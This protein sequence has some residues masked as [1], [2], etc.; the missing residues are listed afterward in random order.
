MTSQVKIRETGG[1]SLAAGIVELLRTFDFFPPGRQVEVNKTF[2]TMLILSI[3]IIVLSIVSLYIKNWVR[4]PLIV[5]LLAAVLLGYD[6]VWALQKK[7]LLDASGLKWS[8]L[9]WV[10]VGGPFLAVAATV[11]WLR[12]KPNSPAA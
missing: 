7:A 6:H 3:A 4:W 9:I 10:V 11:L 1:L 12:E 2:M 5:T 8:E